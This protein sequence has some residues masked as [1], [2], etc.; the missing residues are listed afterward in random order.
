MSSRTISIFLHGSSRFL[1]AFAIA[2]AALCAE[3]A[4]AIER[5]RTRTA[6]G[7]LDDYMLKDIGISRSDIDR[8]SSRSL[9]QRKAG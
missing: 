3:I 5:R 6:L 4:A 2:V 8:I 7:R 1:R 9:H